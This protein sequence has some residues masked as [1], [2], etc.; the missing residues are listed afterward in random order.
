M[1]SLPEGGSWIT[2][3]QIQTATLRLYSILLPAGETPTRHS[4]AVQCWLCL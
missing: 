3:G 1:E 4:Q 2:W